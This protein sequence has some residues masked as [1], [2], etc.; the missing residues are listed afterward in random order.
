MKKDLIRECNDRNLKTSEFEYMFCNQCKNR[1]CPRAS[2]SKSSWDERIL[3]QV[4]RL[5]IN[6]NIQDQ[7]SS[8]R[9]DGIQDFIEFIEKEDWN[10]AHYQTQEITSKTP[11]EIKIEPVQ[12]IKIEPVQE[13]KI[14][15]SPLNTSFSAPMMIGGVQEIRTE[16]S[17]DDWA[18]D[19]KSI[20]VGATF[21]MGG[22]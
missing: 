11:Q 15:P 8:T 10:V 21:K 9:W 1:S 5:L 13:I 20:K 18:V 4:D 19:K 17:V 3:N 12:E 22:K 16:V 2:W 6:P 7:K 14:I